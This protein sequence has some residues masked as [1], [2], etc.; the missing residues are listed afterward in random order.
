MVGGQ[1]V[2]DVSAFGGLAWGIATGGTPLAHLAM[3]KVCWAVPSMTK[4]MNVT[5]LEEDILAAIDDAIG[6][7][8]MS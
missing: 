2:P 7:G 8:S 6:D 4:Q 5:C 3:Y 1:K